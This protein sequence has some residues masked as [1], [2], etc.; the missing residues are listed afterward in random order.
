MAAAAFLR[1]V[2]S[3]TSWHDVADVLDGE[4]RVLVLRVD[5]D[6]PVTQPTH[7]QYGPGGKRRS[8]YPRPEG[9]TKG[10]VSR[11]RQ[12]VRKKKKEKVEVH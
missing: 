3:Q 7:G 1:C 11:T 6:H 8:S 2:S 12:E 9:I 4:S 5:P 10:E